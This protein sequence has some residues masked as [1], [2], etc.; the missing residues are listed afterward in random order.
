MEA[1]PDLHIYHFAPYEPAALKRL[2]GRYLSREAELDTLLRAERFV[3]LYSVV[4]NGLRAGV[5]SYSIKK[6]EALYDYARTVSLTDANRGLFKVEAHLEL[7]DFEFIS[8]DDLAAVAGYNRDDCLSTRAL[9]DW[10]EKCRRS[11][12]VEGADIPR[13]DAARRRVGS[14]R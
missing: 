3:D 6:L 8:D 7:D 4:R 1:W 13:P 10:L 5:E 2:M 11:L 9:R 12:I 14:D